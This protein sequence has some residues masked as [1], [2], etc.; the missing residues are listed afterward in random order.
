MES[1]QEVNQPRKYKNNK[2]QK[3]YN[4]KGKFWSNKLI[5]EKKFK[6][7]FGDESPEKIRKNKK[8]YSDQLI[9]IFFMNTVDPFVNFTPEDYLYSFRQ[10]SLKFLNQRFDNLSIYGFVYG[11][12]CR[13][14]PE[15]AYEYVKKFSKLM[16][17]EDLI[18]LGKS[19][20][21]R[22][23]Y[24]VH[25]FDCDNETILQIY[26]ENFECRFLSKSLFLDFSCVKISQLMILNCL[27]HENFEL[28]KFLAESFCRKNK[29]I[30]IDYCNLP[31]RYKNLILDKEI[32]ETLY[33]KDYESIIEENA[34]LFDVLKVLK[35]KNFKFTIIN[36]EEGNLEK[37]LR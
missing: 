15:L 11:Y 37:F 2:Y 3:R 10:M 33:K 36:D 18:F 5:N 13:S 32:I 25:D 12:E 31:I 22:L 28:A 30:Q 1:N 8:I 20:F 35:N 9:N 17:P 24:N 14:I 34:Q 29:S 23:R 7:H 6:K 27:Y 16:G 4:P 26:T 21:S 19:K